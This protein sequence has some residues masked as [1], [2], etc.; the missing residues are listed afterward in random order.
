MQVVTW[1]VDFR[2]ISFAKVN[3]SHYYRSLTLKAQSFPNWPASTT[4]PIFLLK[5]LLSRAS[6]NPDK[7]LWICVPTNYG[8]YWRQMRTKI[9][10]KRAHSHLP[11][12]LLNCLNTLALAT[13]FLSR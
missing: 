13:L 2:K 11:G 9:I 1:W 12:I 8:M 10:A 7:P 5:D 6:C 4:K 3:V